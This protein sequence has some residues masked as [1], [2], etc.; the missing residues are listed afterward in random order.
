[1]AAC[2]LPVVQERMVVH[3]RIKVHTH[4][5]FHATG[6]D[7]DGFL[8]TGD[9]TSSPLGSPNRFSIAEWQTRILAGT[10]QGKPEQTT[11]C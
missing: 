1:V 10:G 5:F 3:E 6:D 9:E 2:V 8:T 11:H 4:Q 7:D